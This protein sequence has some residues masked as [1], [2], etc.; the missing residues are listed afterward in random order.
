M[1]REE[2]LEE[3]RREFP[4]FRICYKRKSPLSRAIHWAL[5]ALTMGRQRDFLTGYYTVIGD[6][7]YVPDSWDA[8]DDVD[9][10]I[11]LRHER[12]HLRQR[13]RYGA[14]GMAFLYL[15]PFFPLGLAYGRA[16]LE[17]EAYTETL[18][19]TAERRGLAAARD[20][21]LRARIVE[22]FVGPAYGWMW[23]F[24]KRVER[25]YDEALADLERG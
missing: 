23:P 15:V 19:A 10:E 14:L 6:T 13:R 20:P 3:L 7:L 9:C 17:W 22:R 12:V 18:R 1:T 2:L 5:V 24:R 21:Q 4:R 11:L 25:W 16:R 8:L